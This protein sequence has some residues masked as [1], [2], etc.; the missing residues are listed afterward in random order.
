MSGEAKKRK[1]AGK[2]KGK[3]D[4]DLNNGIISPGELFCSIVEKL[5]LQLRG[6]S[7]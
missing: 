5:Y 3:K 4:V 1:F 7:L 2:G 6:D